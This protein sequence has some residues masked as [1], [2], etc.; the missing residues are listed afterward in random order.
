MRETSRNIGIETPWLKGTTYGSVPGL[1][2]ANLL[3]CGTELL[4]G[5]HGLQ[6]LEDEVPEGVVLLVEEKDNAG[7]LR[8][9]R[10]GDVEDDFLSDVLNLLVGDGGLLV[11]GIVGAALLDGVEERLGGSHC[12]GSGVR[13]SKRGRNGSR[14]GSSE[15][16]CCLLDRCHGGDLSSFIPGSGAEGLFGNL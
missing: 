5:N 1:E 15:G 3:L 9:E 8:V 13:V 12:C 6:D 7:A 16:C 2:A 10:G 14:L 4:R 11:Q